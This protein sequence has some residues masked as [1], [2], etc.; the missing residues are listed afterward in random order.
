MNSEEENKVL[1]AWQSSARYWDKY[2]VLIAR[3]FAPLTSGLIE[4]ARIG[5][6]QKVLDIGGGSGEPSLTIA[7]V[8]GSTGSVVY[9]DPVAGMVEITRSEA[10]RRGLTNIDFR[11]CSGENL[12]FPDATFDVGVS[13]LSSMFFGD[14]I[15]GVR[16]VLRVIVRNGHVSFVVWGPAENNPF[17]SCVS[18]VVDRFVE[19]PE[20]DPDAPDAFRF[21]VPG[22]LAGIL[23][24]AG[25]ENVIERQLNFQIE[26]KISPEQFWQLRTEMSESL[27]GKIADLASDKLPMLKQAAIDALRQ[28]FVNGKMSFPAEAFIV[29]GRKE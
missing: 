5:M 1:N 19:S 22:K 10:G 29:T 25:A 15:S 12:P 23:K 17:F 16:E 8:V 3:M 24:K 18:D 14:A 28:Y 21:A 27:R 11:Q 2:R 4:E 9:T 13:R 6:G 7:S 20:Q 26:G